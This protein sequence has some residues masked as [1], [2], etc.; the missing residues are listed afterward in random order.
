MA[1]VRDGMST[2]LTSDSSLLV[3]SSPQPDHQIGKGK[4]RGNTHSASN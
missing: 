1:R 3:V 4:K 2:I